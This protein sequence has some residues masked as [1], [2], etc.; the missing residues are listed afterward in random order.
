ME[1]RNYVN[2]FH[3]N[4]VCKFNTLRCQSGPTILW[5]FRRDSGVLRRLRLPIPIRFVYIRIGREVNTNVMPTADRC[6]RFA[7]NYCSIR[8]LVPS[9]CTQC[10]Y[11]F[12]AVVNTEQR[13]RVLYTHAVYYYKNPKAIRNPRIKIQFK[14]DNER[15]EKSKNK[16]KIFIKVYIIQHGEQKK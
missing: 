1:H 14:T 7:N 11:Y 4:V 9:D 8:V 6:C 15:R 16:I 2:P 12:C 10:I 3:N 13:A 5:S